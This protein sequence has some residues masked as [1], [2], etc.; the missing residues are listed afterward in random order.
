VNLSSFVHSKYFPLS[1]SD[2]VHVYCSSNNTQEE[3]RPWIL[4]ANETSV[5]IKSKSPE[6]N[7]PPPVPQTLIYISCGWES[8]KEVFLY[9]FIWMYFD[10]YQN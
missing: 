9:S 3:K 6:A 2:L 8:F 4:R 7:I 5:H 1:V 10:F